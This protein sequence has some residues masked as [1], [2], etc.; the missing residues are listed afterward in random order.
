MEIPLYSQSPSLSLSLPTT[1]TSGFEFK[2]QLCHCRLYDFG[3]GVSFSE[4]QFFFIYKIG[5]DLL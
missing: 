1:H 4:P 5:I 3:Q 2:Y